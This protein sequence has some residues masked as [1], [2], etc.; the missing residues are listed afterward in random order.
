MHN[1]GIQYLACDS[2]D[3]SIEINYYPWFPNGGE[4][5]ASTNY[6]INVAPSIIN[7]Y[8]KEVVISAPELWSSETPS[9][10]KV[11]VILKDKEGNDN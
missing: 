9:L 10:Y 4:K 5:I 11:E 6:S 3:G 1:I 8:T 7:E 2:F